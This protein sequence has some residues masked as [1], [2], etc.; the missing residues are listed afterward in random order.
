MPEEQSQ[1]V[2]DMFAR[3]GFHAEQRQKRMSELL[4]DTMQIVLWLPRLR[5]PEPRHRPV[6]V[7]LAAPTEGSL[8][9]E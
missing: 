6:P 8:D 2:S 4:R 1:L 9:M 3:E 7:L 5:I